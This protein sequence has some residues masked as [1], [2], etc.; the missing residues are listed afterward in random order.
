[1]AVSRGWLS[2]C[3]PEVQRDLIRVMRLIGL[4]SD[5]YLFRATDEPGGIFCG[6]SGTI[7]AMAYSPTRGETLAHIVTTGVWFGQG[8]AVLRTQ[9]SLS[10]RTAGPV[11]LLHIT[12]S[13]LDRVSQRSVNHMRA[14][15]S[16]TELGMREMMA[17]IDTLLIPSATRRIAATLIRVAY[18]AIGPQPDESLTIML[19]QS[20]LGEMANASRNVASRALKDMERKGWIS[21]G[22]RTL[23][24]INPDSIRAFGA[25]HDSN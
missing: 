23:T 7:K 15:A 10:F 8:P 19:T 12:L 25:E 6:V 5:Q 3:Q 11:E 4:G 21:I 2:V 20:E 14:L 16:L 9:R 1:M 22:Y 18:G 17:I 13:D 24:I